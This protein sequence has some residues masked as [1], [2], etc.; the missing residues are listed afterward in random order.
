M[1]KPKRRADIDRKRSGR[2]ANPRRN[3]TAPAK[4][5]AYWDRAAEHNVRDWADWARG[6][7]TVAA[8]DELGEDPLEALEVLK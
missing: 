2:H 3:L 7:L 5:F 4:A 8:A 1:S 6:V